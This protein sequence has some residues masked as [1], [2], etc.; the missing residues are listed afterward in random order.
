MNTSTILEKILTHKQFEIQRNSQAVSMAMQ[1]KLARDLVAER[2]G[3]IRAMRERM[4]A[5]QAAVIA[6]IKKASPS[7]GLIREDFD[8]AT[9]ARQYAEGGATCLSVLT[10]EQYFQ[11]S[12]AYLQQAR[13]ACELPVIRKD[14]IID[15]YQIAE[16][17]AIGADCIL[18]IVAAL[19]PVRLRELAACAAD[20]QLDVL[21]EVHNETE[22][23]IALAGGF[24]L[25]GI[26]NRNL[27]DFHTDL[28]ITFRLAELVPDDKLIV[29]ES[30][31]STAADVKRMMS[32]GIYGFLIGET[33]MRA[34]DPGAKLREL[35]S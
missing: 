16:A 35:F 21:V 3:F 1:D 28:E 30:G 19:N 11:G 18:L 17:G 26:N 32:R 24:D 27:H 15:P 8:P 2:R 14:F 33:F 7:K 6:E 34:P 4:H 25:I 23:D 20:Y 31:I 13:A 29:T 9:L 10:D 12:N 22:L 5:Q